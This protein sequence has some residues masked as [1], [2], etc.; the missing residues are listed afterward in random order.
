[1][2]TRNSRRRLTLTET[3]RKVVGFAMLYGAGVRT[4]G[5]S[6]KR[7]YK[8][9][10]PAELKQYALDALAFKKGRKDQGGV[11]R[12]GS[13]SGCYN[14]MEQIALRTRVPTLPCLGTKISTALRPSAVGTDFHTGRINWT[15]QS[16]GAEMLAI[17]LVATHWLA[18]KFK[19][20]AQFIL[21]IHDETWFMVPEK[22]AQHFA[23]AFQMAHVYSWARFQ[24]A[25]DI[26]D[27]PLSR[28]FFSGVAIDDRLR[29][30]PS[31]KTVT[32]SNP[33]GGSEPFG[34]EF[35]MK[36]MAELGWVDKLAKRAKLVERGLV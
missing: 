1:M 17:L 22:Y 35:S 30:S 27:L 21:S 33:S 5:N 28:A 9:R 6:I 13:D 15:I 10:K 18:R 11:Y 16:S 29:K 23:V 24:S 19:I 3:Q 32:P 7:V 4:L 36:R 8:D 14:F 34:E 26:N 2:H 20:P 31:E 12:G 25:C